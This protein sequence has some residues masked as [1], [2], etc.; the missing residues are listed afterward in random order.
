MAEFYHD[1]VVEKSYQILQDLRRKFSFVLIGG[2]A[3]FVYTKALKSKDVDI[4]VGYEELEKLRQDFQVSKNDRLKKYE[5][6]MGEVDVD[7]YVP[8][9]SSLGLPV[10]EIQK[11]T[12][13]VEG[14]I[15]P[16]PEVLLLLKIY[17]ARERQGTSKGRKD[18]IDIF[19]LLQLPTIDGKKFRELSQNYGVDELGDELK[20]IVSRESA[21]PELRLLEHQMA[22]FK[23]IILSKFAER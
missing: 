17:V 23:K 1:L 10:E 18:V 21:I 4:I 15:V 8:F 2:W 13:S 11:F 19:S 14:F 16:I 22:R 5:I 12:Q 7:I 6:K 9:Y 3:V 20:N